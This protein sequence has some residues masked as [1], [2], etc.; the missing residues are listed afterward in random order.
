M[1]AQVL[2]DLLELTPPGPLVAYTLA[3]WLSLLLFHLFDLLLL[4]LRLLLD[5][6]LDCL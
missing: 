2:V 6:E 5:H 1:M 4:Q 3:D